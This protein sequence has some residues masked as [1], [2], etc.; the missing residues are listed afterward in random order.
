MPEVSRAG[1]TS[2]WASSEIEAL[3]DWPAEPAGVCTL[4]EQ[5]SLGQGDNM[6]SLMNSINKR[7]LKT[8]LTISWITISSRFKERWTMSLIKGIRKSF[9]NFKAGQNTT[10]RCG[11]T[12]PTTYCSSRTHQSSICQSRI[13]TSSLSNGPVSILP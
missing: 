9:P 6:T 5:T 8:P 13:C 2:R 11:E 10:L 1:V 7:F 4:Q 12:P 3:R